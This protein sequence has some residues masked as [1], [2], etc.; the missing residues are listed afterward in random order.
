MGSQLAKIVSSLLA[1]LVRVEDQHD[2]TDIVG[3]RQ[4]KVRDGERC[5]ASRYSRLDAAGVQ[6]GRVPLC[7]RSSLS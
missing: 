2:L 7:P 1:S 6:S 3:D 4:F 5:A